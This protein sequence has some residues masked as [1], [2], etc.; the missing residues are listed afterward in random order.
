MPETHWLRRGESRCTSTPARC[1]RGLSLELSRR[2]PE[3]ASLDWSREEV[4]DRVGER[5]VAAKSSRRGRGSVRYGRRR[6]EA[7]ETG[8]DG[9]SSAPL[10]CVGRW[11]LLHGPWA[12][13]PYLILCRV[14]RVSTAAEGEGKRWRSANAR[15]RADAEEKAE[16]YRRRGRSVRRVLTCRLSIGSSPVSRVHQQTGS[17]PP[18]RRICSLPRHD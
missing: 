5:P 9:T 18:I 4:E 13:R 11:R 7:K 6:G 1:D 14:S 8:G 3:L 10:G 2:S 15:C 16:E 12:D 17:P